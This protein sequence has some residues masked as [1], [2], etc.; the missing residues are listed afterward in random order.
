MVR[1]YD[2][3]ATEA[4]IVKGRMEN[5]WLGWH[6]GSRCSA[7]WHLP[8]L[9]LTSPNSSECSY[10][11]PVAMPTAVPT[12]RKLPSTALLGDQAIAYAGLGQ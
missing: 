12:L 9:A 8:D 1:L 6:R 2:K 4:T 5:R 10:A 3:L 11:R 7:V